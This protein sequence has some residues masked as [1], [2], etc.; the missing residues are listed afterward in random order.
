VRNLL[1]GTPIRHRSGP[2]VPRCRQLLLDCLDCRPQSG[3]PWLGSRK[4]AFRVCGELHLSTHP[5]SKLE[6]CRR[7]AA[8]LAK[9]ASRLINLNRGFPSPCPLWEKISLPA[10]AAGGHHAKWERHTTKSQ[11]ALGHLAGCKMHPN[12]TQ[13]TDFSSPNHSITLLECVAGTT[14]LEPATSA[15]TAPSVSLERTL[16]TRQRSFEASTK[17]PPCSKHSALYSS[18]RDTQGRR[19]LFGIELVD[20]AQ[21]EG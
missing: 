8:T 6:L 12:R 17:M 20:V 14:G 9:T 21:D 16:R 18:N 5:S 4:T 11:E 7:K 10:T 2:L 19:R 3:H 15:V 13:F 1:H